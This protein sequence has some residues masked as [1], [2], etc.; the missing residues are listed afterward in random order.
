MPVRG[1]SHSFGEES[2]EVK[3]TDT[4]LPGEDA[5]IQTFRQVRLDVL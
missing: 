5:K 4:R 2:R 3:G 1:C